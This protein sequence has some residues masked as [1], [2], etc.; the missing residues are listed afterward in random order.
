MS[1]PAHKKEKLK[2]RY[3][4]F[5]FFNFSVF[6]HSPTLCAEVVIEN[7]LRSDS[8]GVKQIVD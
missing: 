3:E 2:N 5:L 7:V 4:V 1:G 8:K 6:Y